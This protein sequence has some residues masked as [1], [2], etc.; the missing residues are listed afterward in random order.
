MTNSESYIATCCP[1]LLPEFR[2][3][4]LASLPREGWC[5]EEKAL[6]LASKILESNPKVCVEVGVFGG[7]SLVP[8]AMALQQDGSKGFIVG[9]DPW[10][11][12]AALE[13]GIGPLNED[14]WKNNV[15]LEDIYRGCLESILQL[16]LTFECRI[17]RARSEQAVR[18]F[19]DKSVDWLHLDSNHSE[20]VSCR[21]VGLWAPKMADK[22]TWI[23]DDTDWTS[24]AVALNRIKDLGFET[25]HD[26]E[27][28]QILCR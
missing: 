14:W 25:V 21:D 28:Y 4:L 6:M 18:M 19:D 9:I 3:R 1:S 10:S 24:Q 22:S 20:L 12:D 16:K 26:G 23:F 11:L 8:Q 2:D 13:G 17:V 27:S 7:R 5:T 15:T